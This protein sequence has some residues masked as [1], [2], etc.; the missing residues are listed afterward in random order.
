L[1]DGRIVY[2]PPFGHKP[3]CIV[4]EIAFSLYQHEKR[5]RRGDTGTATLAYTVPPLPSGR[6][7]F[8]PAVSFYLG[9]PPANPMSFIE[10][11]PTFAVEVR[12][13]HDFG[14]EAEAA[15]VAKRVDYFQAGT[16]VVWDIDSLADSITAYRGDAR[17]PV[18]VYRR[19]DTAD[20]EP[21]MPGWS[22]AV[23]E[24]FDAD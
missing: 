12:S 10:G 21:A 9:P 16:L 13:E 2:Y 4:G 8:S 1:V 23:D 19:G 6:E 7:S 11:P 24:I 5:T 15:M 18:A 17:S 3:G 22:I 20:A 14:P